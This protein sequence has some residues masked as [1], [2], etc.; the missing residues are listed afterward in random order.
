MTR[1]SQDFFVVVPGSVYPE[2]LTAGTEVS[3]RLAQMAAAC[4]VLEATDAKA[5]KAPKAA[6]RAPEKQAVMN[7]PETK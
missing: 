5:K 1:L 6:Q 7:A 2:T 4:G 3:G